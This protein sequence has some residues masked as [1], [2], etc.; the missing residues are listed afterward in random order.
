MSGVHLRAKRVVVRGVDACKLETA[1]VEVLRSIEVDTETAHQAYKQWM[2]RT[3]R[4]SDAG[5]VC[6]PA[7]IDR[8]LTLRTDGQ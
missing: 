2:E 4:R 8:S 6:P 3:R 7:G 1:G 5:G